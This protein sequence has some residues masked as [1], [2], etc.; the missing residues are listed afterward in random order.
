MMCATALV[1]HCDDAAADRLEAEGWTVLRNAQA[2]CHHGFYSPHLA[3]LNQP[4]WRDRVAP[5]RRVAVRM[6]KP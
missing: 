2:W 1:A 6:T 5:V 3:V 4:G